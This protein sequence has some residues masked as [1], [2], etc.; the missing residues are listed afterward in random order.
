MLHRLLK[1]S[2]LILMMGL[3]LTV[4]AE[5]KTY[6]ML[7]WEQLIPASAKQS[8]VSGYVEHDQYTGGDAPQAG[9]PVVTALNGKDV[10]IAGFAVPLE[11]NDEGVT[12]LLLVPFMGA[13]VHVPPPPSNQIVYV[14]TQKPLSFDLIYDAFWVYGRLQASTFTSELA[15][16]GYQLTADRF[17]AYVYDAQ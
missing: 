1:T 16:A 12:E 14:K 17:E 5:D 4:I 7:K 15:E 3:S 6:E 11:G 13:C 2:G 8:V 9:A 10:K